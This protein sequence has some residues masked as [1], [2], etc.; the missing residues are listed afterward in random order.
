MNGAAIGMG[1]STVD[2]PTDDMQTNANAAVMSLD[3][4]ARTALAAILS[5]TGIDKKETSML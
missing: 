4:S 5:R 2:E 3:N 1:K